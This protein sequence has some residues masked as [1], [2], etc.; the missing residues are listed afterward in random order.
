MK[1]QNRW[2]SLFLFAIGMGVSL[3]S[4]RLP[5]G[6]LR[7]P[8]EGFT[9]FFFGLILG[10]LSLLNFFLE[11]EKKGDTQ[12]KREYRSVWLTSGALA[13]YAILFSPL[14]YLLATFGVILWILRLVYRV[15]WVTA[16]I[17]SGGAAGISFLFFVYGLNVPLPPGILRTL[18]R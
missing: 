2:S 3:L 16:L 15:G 8:K 12:A 17:F 4:R 11:H 13:F 14:G 9:P 6:S 10:G 5:L 7:E 1:L 18:M